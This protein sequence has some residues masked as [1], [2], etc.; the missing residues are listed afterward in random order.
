MRIVICVSAAHTMVAII[1]Y[2]PHASF[3]ILYHWKTCQTHATTYF[4]GHKTPH[5]QCV[6]RA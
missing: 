4:R 3:P 1:I 6:L 2:N 5:H